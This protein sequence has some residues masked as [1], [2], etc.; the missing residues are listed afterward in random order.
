M[1]NAL[2][3]GDVRA[4]D[5]AV[6]KMNSEAAAQATSKVDLQLKQLVKQK[7]IPE[8]PGT[9]GYSQLRAKMVADEAAKIRSK[10]KFPAAAPR[11][12]TGEIRKALLSK[13]KGVASKGFKGTAQVIG[14]AAGLLGMD[15]FWRQFL[16]GTTQKQ[17]LERTQAEARRMAALERAKLWDYGA[18]R[19][20]LNA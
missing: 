16:S 19:P 5:D 9:L 12:N 20:L 18:R 8:R 14:G 6:R 11:A 13:P 1:A 17:I 4:W 15:A 7:K 3:E 2:T 10:W